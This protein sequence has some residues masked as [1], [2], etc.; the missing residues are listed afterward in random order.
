MTRYNGNVAKVLKRRRPTVNVHTHP[1]GAKAVHVNGNGVQVAGYECLHVLITKEHGAWLAQGLEI[2]YCID[3]PTVPDVKHRFET[4]LAMTIESHLRVNN[5]I[6]DLL[7]VAPQEIWSKY[8]HQ[9]HTLHRFTHSQVLTRQLQRHLPF[10][11]IVW[12][13]KKRATG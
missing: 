13:E 5:N 8:W 1:S 11:Q 4:G 10:D 12:V 3:G 7:R 2:D 9:D 6:D